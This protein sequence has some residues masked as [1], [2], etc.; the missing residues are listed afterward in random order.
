MTRTPAPGPRSGPLFRF[1]VW[2]LTV[3]PPGSPRYEGKTPLRVPMIVLLPCFASVCLVALIA[4]AFLAEYDLAPLLFLGSDGHLLDLP[5]I[6]LRLAIFTAGATCLYLLMVL[7]GG[8][9]IV[10]LAFAFRRSLTD[11]DLLG[12]FP[13]WVPVPLLGPILRCGLRLVADNRPPAVSS[14]PTETTRDEARQ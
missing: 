11:E 13:S 5:A 12:I 7:V 6:I 2:S 10:A 3:R 1:L 8:L 4:C 9:G 14:R